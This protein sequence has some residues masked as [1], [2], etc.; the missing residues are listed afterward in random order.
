VSNVYAAKRALFDRL[1]RLVAEAQEGSPLW[2]FAVSYV[3]PGDTNAGLKQIYGGRPSFEHPGED[4]MEEGDDTAFHEV[5]SVMLSVRAT[6]SP[7]PDAGQRASDEIVE[8]TVFEI[9]RLLRGN[10][11]LCGGQ[12]V[13]RIRS[14]VGDNLP[15]NDGAVSLMSLR[16]D[17]ESYVDYG[18]E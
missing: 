14:G 11:H 10:K 18:E 12:S 16:V 4:D 9:G 5:A 2:G 17:I 13:A 6:V 3:W 1:G 8:E 7:F 15:H